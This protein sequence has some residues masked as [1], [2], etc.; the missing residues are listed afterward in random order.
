MFNICEQRFRTTLFHNKMHC[1]YNYYNNII[2]NN[3]KNII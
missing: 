2:Y 3:S 1:E